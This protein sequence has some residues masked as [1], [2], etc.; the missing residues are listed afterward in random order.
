MLGKLLKD[1]A[2]YAFDPS[3]VF[4]F[5]ALA[6]SVV[7]TVTMPEDIKKA[8]VKAGGVDGLVAG[9]HPDHPEVTRTVL[10]ALEMLTANCADVK[11]RVRIRGGI[12]QLVAVVGS[13]HADRVH[14]PTLAALA[15]STL[16]KL[17]ANN[18]TNAEVRHPPGSNSL[19]SSLPHLPP[20]PGG[21]SD[22]VRCVVSPQAIR[23]C[24]GA[25]QVFV[26]I[27]ST[28]DAG[29]LR[30][31]RAARL[32]AATCVMHLTKYDELSRH[33][34]REEGLLPQV[35]RLS[36]SMDDGVAERGV[37]TL[38]NMCSKNAVNQQAVMELEGTKVRSLPPDSLPVWH[39]C[40]HLPPHRLCAFAL[41]LHQCTTF[42][43][44]YF[45]FHPRSTWLVETARREKRAGDFD[46]R[47]RKANSTE[48]FRDADATRTDLIAASASVV[49][50]ADDGAGAQRADGAAA[51][52]AA[53]RSAGHRGAPV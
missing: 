1:Q 20:S 25:L 4:R 34:L 24:D 30:D 5:A 52:Q 53:A 8:V 17:S 16:A 40:W 33:V 13:T 46:Q 37:W 27:A 7:C 22:G 15:C 6:L 35:M 3:E 26:G 47:T 44:A 11:E 31:V 38:S 42:R 28:A 50:D 14:G 48:E 49:A 21:S 9:I 51:P 43:H 18:A 29:G 39:P 32:H 12:T 10:T 41:T 36:L 19:P 45:P 2:G 23:E